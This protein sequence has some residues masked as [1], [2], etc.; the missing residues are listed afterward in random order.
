MIT[1]SIRYSYKIYD[2]RVA[3]E[4]LQEQKE[5]TVNLHAAFN[6]HNKLVFDDPYA[7]D[8]PLVALEAAERRTSQPRDTSLRPK[9]RSSIIIEKGEGRSSREFEIQ[10]WPEIYKTGFG[11][12]SFRFFVNK[13]HI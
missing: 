9:V 13:V 7:I 8:D 12:L 10:W 11:K 2:E 1:E 4:L 6:E 3:I 5:V